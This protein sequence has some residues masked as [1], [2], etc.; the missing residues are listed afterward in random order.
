MEILWNRTSRTVWNRLAQGGAFQQDWAYGEACAALGSSVLRAEI[1]DHGRRAGVV[2]LIHR[3]FLRGLHVAVGTRGPVW[4]PDVPA[5]LMAAALRALSKSLPLPV[6]RG[7]F[8]TPE[9]CADGSLPASG[10]QRVMTPYATVLLDLAKTPEQLRSNLHQKW[11]NRLTAAERSGLK[12][13]RADARPHHYLWL[14]EAE[15]HQQT[16]LRYRALPTALVPAWHA[17]GG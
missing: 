2:Q 12:I 13:L 1:R 16:R 7:L 17:G 11:R 8:L 14:L 6:L 10:F 3:R 9:A 4:Q 5:D 15:Q